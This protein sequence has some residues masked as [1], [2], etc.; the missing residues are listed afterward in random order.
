M[1]SIYAFIPIRHLLLLKLIV[2][3]YTYIQKLDVKDLVSHIQQFVSKT[4][5]S[6]W[7]QQSD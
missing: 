3:T 7:P 5:H 1:W 6:R 4:A 2:Q